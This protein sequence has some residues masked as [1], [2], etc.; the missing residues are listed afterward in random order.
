MAT[1][2]TVMTWNIEN[3]FQPDDTAD[4]EVRDTYRQKLGLIGNTVRGLMPDIVAFQEV[5]SA[6]AFDELR[7]ALGDGYEHRRL[8]A[9]PDGRGIRVGFICRQPIV[10][11]EDIVDFPDGPALAISTIDADGN[12]VPLT[13]MGRGALR[14]RIGID[15]RT[16]DLITVHLKSKLLSF[17]SR[18]G[19]RFQPRDELERAQVAGIALMQ[20]SAE[21]VTVRLRANELLVGNAATPLI[22]LGDLNDV[23]DSATAQMLNGPPG[24]EIGTGGFQP[25][26]RGDDARLFN[27]A[28]LIPDE[29]RYSRVFRGRGEL[30]DQILVSEEMMPRG[31]DG[32]RRLPSE[33]TSHVNVGDGLASIEEDPRRRRD[34]AV[35]DHAPVTATFEL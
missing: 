19:G 29:T 4:E 18:E 26:D 9:A 14:V 17:P 7:D 30:L 11:A 21:S 28:P 25:A 22:V 33:V 27:L 35:P 3:L 15:G 8:S 10:D 6:A 34:E 24:S 1:P 5:G 20:R 12:A 31:D 16:V 2:L 13:R 32:R 23:P